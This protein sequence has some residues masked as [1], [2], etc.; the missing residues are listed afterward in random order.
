[1]QLTRLLCSACPTIP[2][3]FM[4]LGP[5]RPP[6]STRTPLQAISY[7]AAKKQISTLRK[8]AGAAVD[9]IPASSSPA[10]AAA[11]DPVPAPPATTSPAPAADSSAGGSKAA[12]RKQPSG[13]GK[14]AG[15]R[16]RRGRWGLVARAAQ[17][18]A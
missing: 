2:H 12:Q 1:M 7:L 13:S 14:A 8:A 18:E 5:T 4:P 3:C 17:K 6:H 16:V 15:G 11:P 9:H 10:A